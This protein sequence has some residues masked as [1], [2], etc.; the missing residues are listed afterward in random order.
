MSKSLIACAIDAKECALVRLKTSGDTEYSLSLCKTLPFGLG[1]FAFDRGKRLLKKLDNQLNEW[2]DEELALC[3]GPKSYLPLPACF[4]A[5][6]SSEESRKYGRIE[7]GY[8]LNQP[9]EYDFDI[10]SYGDNS[11][12]LLEKK[13]LL[14][15][16]A[17]PC[18]KVSEHFSTTH[19]IVFRG[20]PQLPLLHLS[21]HTSNTQVILE[22][23]NNFIL[24]TI[25][26]KGRIEKFSC[27][28]VKNRK[29]IEYFTIHIL[30][31]NPV[32][33][34]AGVQV[35]GSMADKTMIALI[36]R[37]TS[38]KLKPLGIP[39]S[40]AI[41]N[42]QKLPFSSAAAVKAISSALMALSNNKE[43]ILSSQ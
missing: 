18:R 32:C 16:P 38:I 15:Y 39:P 25:S 27:R 43:F 33:Q 9:E 28:E 8:F 1:D 3:I 20:T 42:P 6:A 36:Q 4:P 11:H 14:F 31:D 26:S 35:T 41:N 19:R 2:P 17:E 37:E 29:E 10:T 12:G 30:I 13:I 21:K 22:V 5:N 34:D 7:A 24:L 40:I 23:E